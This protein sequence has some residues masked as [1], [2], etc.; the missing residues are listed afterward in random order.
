[1]VLKVEKAL[2]IGTFNYCDLNFIWDTW[3]FT[4]I[5]KRLKYK[6]SLVLDNNF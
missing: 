2:R 1:M 5:F 6:V 3:H 4:S